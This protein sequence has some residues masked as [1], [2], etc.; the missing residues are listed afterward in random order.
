MILSKV[1]DKV[2]VTKKSSDKANS[3]LPEVTVE[4]TY[5]AT[6]QLKLEKF[7]LLPK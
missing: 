6:R 7:V 4:F 3:F 1:S 5:L 2:T